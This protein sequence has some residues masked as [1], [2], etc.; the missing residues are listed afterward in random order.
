MIELAK[1]SAFF[2]FGSLWLMCADVECKDKQAMTGKEG[3]EDKD[4]IGYSQV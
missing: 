1:H 4:R 2:Q 3:S